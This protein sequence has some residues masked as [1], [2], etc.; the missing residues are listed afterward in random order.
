[1]K[2][3]YVGDTQSNHTVKWM[4][5]FV[6]KGHEVHIIS[7]TM[8][9]AD[10]P[11]GVIV[12]LL[13]R[14]LARFPVINNLSRIA[15]FR[16]ISSAICELSGIIFARR[17]INKVKPDV[18]HCFSLHSFWGA[19]SGFHPLVVFPYGSDLLIR[20]NNC[21][22]IR[23]Q[24]KYICRKA[25]A[26]IVDSLP[27][28]DAAVALGVPPDRNYFVCMGVD[29]VQFNLHVDRNRIRKMYGFGDSPL[30]FSPRGARP[31]YNIDTII[32]SIPEVLKELP[33]AK[34]L[35]TFG[36]GYQQAEL[37]NLAARLGLG[38]SV[39]FVDFVAY[40]EMPFY[41]AAS[42]IC[43][44]V[45][46]SDSL[47]QTIPEAMACSVPTIVSDIPM[48]R[49]IL[50]HGENTLLVPPRD[51]QALSTAILSLLTSQELRQRIVE[52]ALKLVDE[53]LDYHKNM[54][55]LESIYQSLC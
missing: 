22:R 45:P 48:T 52:S 55:Q 35:F 46:S 29:H 26:F 19:L 4:G 2:I 11:R 47:T 51:P 23:L 6:E 14:H 9:R 38:D 49:G 10:M 42:D 8:P 40:Q 21:L 17:V 15:F 16:K 41:Y 3:C 18:L 53:K 39:K 37:R 32:R 33:K 50:T 1:M 12:H 43:I 44:S 25:D 24:Y 20:T 5:Y 31:V 36:H 13:P 34:F 7:S 54:A 27:L 30:I 28:R